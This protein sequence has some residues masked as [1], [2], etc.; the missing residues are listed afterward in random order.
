MIVLLDTSTPDCRL[1][2]VP[3]Q[4]TPKNEWHEYTWHA[5]RTLAHYLL[6]FL[7]DKLAENGETMGSV[8]A[9]GVMQG[10]GSFT[11]L[12]I[13]LTVMNTIASDRQI[14]IIGAVGETWREMVLERLAMGQN[15]QL[16]MPAYGS[17][18][19]ITKPRK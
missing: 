8:A 6:K 12:R 4:T 13:G 18:P 16:V 15:D 17:E 7:H 11:G 3:E 9:I 10:P 2:L 19:H 1:T 14:P 5:D